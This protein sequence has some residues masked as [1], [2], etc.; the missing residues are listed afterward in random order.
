MTEM[1][2]TPP[3]V[4]PNSEIVVSHRYDEPN[5]FRPLP[6]IY[7]ELGRTLFQ[8]E[9]YNEAAQAF[10]DAIRTDPNSAQLRL[11]LAQARERQQRYEDALNSYIEA[12]RLDPSCAVKALK[13]A[14]HWLTRELVKSLPVTLERDWLNAINQFQPGKEARAAI[15]DFLG[16]TSL[17]RADFNRA[18]EHYQQAHFNDPDNLFILEG[19]GEALWRVG[20]SVEAIQI[21]TRA[22]E[23]ADQ[24][25]YMDRRASTR[26]KLAKVLLDAKRSEDALP[27]L[28]EGL[29]LKEK[30][31]TAEFQIALA[32]CYLEMHQPEEA[33][34]LTQDILSH[35][36]GNIDTYV[37]CATADYELKRYEEAA[38]AAEAALNLEPDNLSAIRLKALALIKGDLDLDEAI[39][40]L[41]T[42]TRRKP[43]DLECLLLLTRSL[44][45]Q[46][47]SPEDVASA[48]DGAL[49][50]APQEQQAEF[51][52]EVARIYLDATQPEKAL[53][54]LDEALRWDPKLSSQADFWK[55]YGEAQEQ[56]GQKEKAAESYMQGL[57]LEPSNVALLDR[58]GMLLMGREDPSEAI[59]IWRRVVQLAPDNAEAYMR[60]AQLLQRQGRDSMAL[61]EVGRALEWLDSGASK[62]AAY[63]LEGEILKSLQK[64]ATDVA[65]SYYYAGQEQYFLSDFEAAF[66]LFKE[67][68]N[69]NQNDQP[70][71]WYISDTLRCLAPKDDYPFLDDDK[72][73]QANEY[74]NQGRKISPPSEEFAWAYLCRAFIHE[75]L[76]RFNEDRATNLWKAILSV[77]QMLILNPTSDPWSYLARFHRYLYNDA[78]A[79][80]TSEHG[81]ESGDETGE[82]L[83]ERAWVLASILDE[84]AATVLNKYAGQLKAPDPLVDALK[85]YLLSFQGDYAEAL[86]GF[87]KYLDSNP[88]EIWTLSLRGR[89]LLWAGDRKGA[90]ADFRKCWNLTN[91]GKQRADIGNRE[92]RAWVGYQLGHYDEAIELF[93]GLLDDEAEDPFDLRI[94]LV[95]CALGRGQLADADQW[96]NQALPYLRNMRHVTESLNELKLLKKEHEKIPES[97]A[98]L[99]A[100]TGYEEQI[101]T[102]AETLKGKI[103]DLAAAEQELTDLLAKEKHTEG[104]VAWLAI[105]SSLGRVLSEEGHWEEAAKIY[106]ELNNYSDTFPEASIGLQKT[107][108]SLQLEGDRRLKEGTPNT[109]LEVFS[110]VLVLALPPL[111]EKLIKTR[112]ARKVFRGIA[113]FVGRFRDQKALAES[114]S[115][116]D[117][118]Q[119]SLFSRLGYA[120][121]Q[122]KN[123]D[124]R[125]EFARAL[126]LYRDGG[127]TNPGEALGK[128]CQSLLRDAADYWALVDEWKAFAAS[129][130]DE[131]LKSDLAAATKSLVGFL[132][133]LYYLSEEAASSYELLPGVT[134]MAVEM[135]AALIPDDAG[136]EWSLIKNYL[137]QMRARIAEE[138]GVTIPGV[139]VRANDNM[140]SYGYTIM[141]NDIPLETG[142]LPG[143]KLYCHT[144]IDVLQQLGIPEET[145]DF[146]PHPVTG[147]DGYWIEPEYRDLISHN[148]AAPVHE[149]LIFMVFHIEAVLRSHLADF[150]GLQDVENLL[151]NWEQDERAASR[152]RT[153]LSDETSR[154]R[155][156]RLLRMLVRER[157]PITSREEILDAFEGVPSA[158][159]DLGP[160]E[161]AV[162]LKLKKL[163]PGNQ[164]NCKRVTIPKENEDQIKKWIT[165]KHESTVFVIPPEDRQKMLNEILSLADPN[166]KKVVLVTSSPELRRFVRNLVGRA[167]PELIVLAN[168]EVLEEKLQ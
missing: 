40:L 7:F 106:Y 68:N 127:I 111:T 125:M 101:R 1:D 144:S 30:D 108:D 36:S 4:D 49:A 41:Q 166:D 157:V 54:K 93:T 51:I 163:L 27:V 85:G 76:S 10:R 18:V 145:I 165:D 97:S 23:K 156:A 136:P 17:Y 158:N 100:I 87:G 83:S 114:S 91:P 109:A 34:Q 134:Q 154:F 79:M 141:V 95:F 2:K 28:Q 26:L 126:E 74:W 159:G 47:R 153:V 98:L 81:L 135:G 105:K 92:R 46:G 62:A 143:N 53:T 132:D 39:R 44:R 16:R 128:D 86:R 25:E 24:T 32:R 71:Y 131:T 151:L 102:K 110:R 142:F 112:I 117:I 147:D 22:V 61:E 139:R 8:L 116:H 43:D 104:S 12:V 80:Q 11:K 155:F 33:L 60:L 20:S 124:A 45:Q 5:E 14:H 37:T 56:N 50:N 160:I 89:T 77:E 90:T 140:Y 57:A 65:K 96:F 72:L 21:L 88:D 94:T 148:E 52:S 19:L 149:S 152:I 120:H 115:E 63:K 48:L 118:K 121:F 162:R 59:D 75:S 103:Y 6:Q 67:A 99:A 58:Y 69:L 122:L 35:G 167:F 15:Y 168:E 70:T 84:D 107:L 73:N 78:M 129:E 55:V 138:L 64:P 38:D 133:D 130:T 113:D 31:F 161:R 66:E 9:D 150:L 13:Q 3:P 123:P 42:Y 119:A 29:K 82:E 137:P 146:Q 164:P